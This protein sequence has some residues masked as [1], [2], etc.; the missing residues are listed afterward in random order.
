MVTNTV[1]KNGIKKL[2]NITGYILLANIVLCNSAF[3]ALRVISIEPSKFTSQTMGEVTETDK[4]V[5]EACLNWH[6]SGAKI[7]KVFESSSV[8][9]DRGAISREYYWLPCEIEG[10]LISDG[11]EWNFTLNAAAHAEWND[12][13]QSIYWGCAKDECESLFLLSYDGMAG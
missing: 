3:S 10:K 7:I 9:Q 2:L 6:L 1:I 12:G 8:Y 5:E 11:K 4:S 13:H